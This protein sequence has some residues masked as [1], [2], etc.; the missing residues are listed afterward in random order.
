MQTNALSS[1]STELPRGTLSNNLFAT[2]VSGHIFLRCLHS[3]TVNIIKYLYQCFDTNTWNSGSS[4]ATK[5]SRRMMLSTCQVVLVPVWSPPANV[6]GLP[7]SQPCQNCTP[8]QLQQGKGRNSGPLCARST[9]VGPRLGI[10]EDEGVV[11][12]PSQNGFACCVTM[13][14]RTQK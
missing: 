13:T 7:K 5:T 6:T 10:P 3:F 14:T 2:S 8:A 11:R 4:M 9:R 1:Q 12:L